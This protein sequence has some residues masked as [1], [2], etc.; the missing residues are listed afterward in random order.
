MSCAR[1]TR[2]FAY[3]RVSTTINSEFIFW[4]LH[5][6]HTSYLLVQGFVISVPYAKYLTSPHYRTVYLHLLLFQEFQ[7][8]R[9]Y[10]TV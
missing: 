7:S 9:Q 8:T 2:S 4:F 3:T 10:S 1:C 6:V 5:R